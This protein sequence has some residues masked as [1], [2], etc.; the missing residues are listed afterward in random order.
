[1]ADQDKFLQQFDAVSK[2]ASKYI[3]LT[4]LEIGVPYEITKFRFHESI[5]G[6]CLVVD[7]AI[8]CWLVLP[9]RIGDVVTTEQQLELLNA[10]NYWMIYRGQHSNYT[11]MAIIEFKT[12]QQFVDEQIEATIDMPH[13]SFH[14]DQF[15][16][17]TKVETGVQT[18]EE[19]MVDSE[20]KKEDRNKGASTSKNGPKLK[21]ERK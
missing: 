8:G 15:D 19:K 5:Y 1:M 11:R 18:L 9:K 13:I 10:Q 16:H 21:K 17:G 14:I 2:G 20:P 4:T 3:N 7:L 6:R 12:L